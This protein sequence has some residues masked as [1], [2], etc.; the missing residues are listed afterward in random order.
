M[1]FALRVTG[2]FALF[3]PA[4]LRAEPYSEPVP[5]PA[6]ACGI[7]RAL[8]GKPQFAW[9]ARRIHVLNPIVYETIVR[10][11]INEDYSTSGYG[12]P[13]RGGGTREPNTTLQNET[14]LRDV[15]YVFEFE[16]RTNQTEHRSQREIERIALSYLTS[17]RQYKAPCAGR[18]E[19]AVDTQFLPEGFPAGLP[20]K[21]PIA[22]NMDLGPMLIGMSPIDSAR[23]LWTPVYSRLSMVNGTISVP[24]DP[25]TTKLLPALNADAVRRF[26]GK[27]AA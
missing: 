14:V 25:Y 15:D 4:H 10:S 27:K 17:G 5:T 12:Q 11:A 18:T 2:P 20:A 7:A 1:T 19:F 13:L 26:G 16:I 6:A 9:I 21:K 3:C 23:N 22:R 8:Y 24:L